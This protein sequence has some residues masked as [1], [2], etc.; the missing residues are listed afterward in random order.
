MIPRSLTAEYGA[1]VKWDVRWPPEKVR[2]R[3]RIAA[4]SMVTRRKG[5]ITAR[6]NELKC[7]HVVEIAHQPS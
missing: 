6:M 5:E 1:R 2:M 7:P 4:W 3:G